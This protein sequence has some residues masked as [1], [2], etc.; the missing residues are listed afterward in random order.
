[1]PAH[2]LLPTLPTPPATAQWWLVT[3]SPMAFENIGFT[4][5]VQALSQSPGT[6]HQL[7]KLP[8]SNFNLSFMQSR[9]RSSNFS[10]AQNAILGRWVGVKRVGRS[11][12]WLVHG[13]GIGSRW[14]PCVYT[15]PEKL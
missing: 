3:P 14:S 15:V 8:R 13:L 11:F 4:R 12:G 7:G 5:P 9:E 10:R 2:S 1:M 6:S